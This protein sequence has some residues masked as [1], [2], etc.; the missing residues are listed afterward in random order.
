MLRTRWLLVVGVLLPATSWFLCGDYPAAGQ[1][2]PTAP[3]TG[4][5]VLAINQEAL[6]Q[7]DLALRKPKDKMSARRIRA[8]AFMVALAAQDARS[9]NAGPA[10]ALTALR[11]AAISLAQAA[12]GKIVQVE[13]A[14]RQAALMRAY[15]GTKPQPGSGS[16][17]VN[18]LKTFDMADIMRV[19]DK[20]IKGG[21]GIELQML[22]LENVRRTFRPKQLSDWQPS[23][24]KTV[25]IANLVSKHQPEGGAEKQK[26]WQGFS[27]DMARTAEQTLH[28]AQAKDSKEFKQ[29]LKKLNDSCTACHDVFK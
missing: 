21:Q 2:A 1:P 15:P 9:Q 12:S 27:A 18:L 29:A 19:F 20:P 8:N 10:P 25:M 5:A 17:P 3:V 13:P 11:D 26:Q 4:R 24:L 14:R 22:N 23:A 28:A 16:E 7:I 6:K